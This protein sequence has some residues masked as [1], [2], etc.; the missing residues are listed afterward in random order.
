MLSIG[1]LV[2]PTETVLLRV[3][4]L[5]L[6][7]SAVITLRTRAEVD[8]R[9]LCTRILPAM[10]LGMPLG[11]VALRLLPARGLSLVFAGFVFVLSVLELQSLASARARSAEPAA[12]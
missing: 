3:V 6:V 11:L 10:A 2:L 4:P 7:L 9:A 12:Q 1:S 8:L 5:N